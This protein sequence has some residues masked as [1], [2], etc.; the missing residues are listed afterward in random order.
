MKILLVCAYGM[1]TS[2]IMKKMKEAALAEGVEL[3]VSAHNPVE[4][5]ETRFDVDIILLGPQ[6]T[7]HQEAIKR[8]YPDI[9][10]EP[11]EM[12][13]Y[14][15]MNGKKV[16]ADAISILEANGKKGVGDE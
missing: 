14:G 13:A 7:Y 12:M 4:V 5:A 6:V 1:S 10:V 9:P 2:M 15:M 3:E 16:L 11:I 8:I